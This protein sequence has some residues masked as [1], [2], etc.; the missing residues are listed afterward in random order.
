MDDGLFGTCV[1]TY[2]DK[3]KF[4]YRLPAQL[5][6]DLRTILANLL[7]R[8]YTW[9][10]R[11]TQCCVRAALICGSMEI[12]TDLS[13]CRNFEK[14]EVSEPEPDARYIDRL[15][16]RLEFLQRKKYEF[17]LDVAEK[18][19]EK[20]AEMAALTE[21]EDILGEDGF[22]TAEQWQRGLRESE[23]ET[24]EESARSQD[25]AALPNDDEAELQPS[26]DAKPPLEDET[27]EAESGSHAQEA[28][29]VPQTN[30][31]E[32]Y[33]PLSADEL[34]VLDNA[35][36]V[37]HNT[38]GKEA[39]DTLTKQRPHKAKPHRKIRTHNLR[40]GASRAG[41]KRTD[42]AFI[43]GSNLWVR[44][45]HISSLR[46]SDIVGFVA[47]LNRLSGRALVGSDFRVQN[48]SSE[49]YFRLA[50][51]TKIADVQK[52]FDTKST[53]DVLSDHGRMKWSSYGFG[54]PENRVEAAE[55]GADP[56]QQAR[57]TSTLLVCGLV[58]VMI[59]ALF[60]VFLVQRF[61]SSK[62]RLRDLTAPFST[63]GDADYRD[64]CRQRMTEK[65]GEQREPVSAAA[66]QIAAAKPAAGSPN[67]STGSWGEDP[68]TTDMDITT[69]HLILSYME[70]YLG[71]K[72]KLEQE[73][74]GLCSYEADQSSCAA[75]AEPE[76]AAKN[77]YSDLL[78]YDHSRVILRKEQN[79]TGSDYINASSISDS[80]PKMKA[81]I[82][83]QGPTAETMNDFWQMVWECGAATIVNLTRLMS[84]DG[85]RELCVQYWPSEGSRLFHRF[86]VH[87][88]SEHIWCEDFVV[89]NFYLKN[90]AS[91]E[92]RTVTMFH[93]LTWAEEELPPS[94][95][96]LLDFRRKVNKSYKGRASPLVIHCNDGCGRTGTYCLL[97][98]ALNRINK[99][100]KEIDLAASLE[101]LRDQRAGLVKTEDQFEFVIT[102][103]AEEVHNVLK[104]LPQ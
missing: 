30:K 77:R 92:A 88:V 42:P 95:K 101:H 28:A 5:Q 61:R 4:T 49:V 83:S 24:A 89:R 65:S 9:H 1:A 15:A 44:F 70:E 21:A 64:L 75:A 20:D 14:P 78:P 100:V 71:N 59:A 80:D 40:T 8:N 36:T 17:G 58:L 86:E 84:A 16:K 52:I 74:A 35:K 23:R 38:E 34:E 102:A 41:K 81:Y 97:D 33:S 104:T 99:G 67:S 10:H 60:V 25:E 73:W 50:P 96:S 19:L 63:G 26:R 72:Q 31:F 98:L 18:R 45:D 3:A 57:I 47:R 91:G 2:T 27:E 103:I 66:Q 69:G 79:A 29:P 82:L 7:E 87:L 12:P 62:W 90:L 85:N 56:G 37:T 55:L 11:F 22:R 68:I 6:K 76:N 13:V 46:E 39:P 53:A 93:F 94:A 51:Q 43:D 54:Q 48:S 32:D